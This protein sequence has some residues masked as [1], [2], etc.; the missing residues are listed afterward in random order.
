[1]SYLNETLWVGI[2]SR[3]VKGPADSWRRERR[4]ARSVVGPGS[5]DPPSKAVETIGTALPRKWPPAPEARPSPHPPTH[6]PTFWVFTLEVAISTQSATNPKTSGRY[7]SCARIPGQVSKRSAPKRFSPPD[8]TTRCA[9]SPARAARRSTPSP[10]TGLTRSRDAV[11]TASRGGG[12]TGQAG[13]G[14]DRG[15]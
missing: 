14:F 13:V 10:S 8:P 9:G 6:T 3:Y 12:D 15:G 7:A 5:H 2:S 11:R 4:S 1:M